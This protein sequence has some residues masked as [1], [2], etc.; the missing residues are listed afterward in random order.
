MHVSSGAHQEWA[1]KVDKEE[2]NPPDQ[3]ANALGV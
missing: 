3:G 1:P 2:G